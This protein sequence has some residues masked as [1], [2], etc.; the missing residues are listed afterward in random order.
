M[1]DIAWRRELRRGRAYYCSPALALGMLLVLGLVGCDFGAM[2][3]APKSHDQQPALTPGTPGV[4]VAPAGWRR[5]L[6]GQALTD[7]T[8]EN[9]MAV[10]PA[11]P[12]RL[13]AC[14]LPNT[15][16][17]AQPVFLLS[18]DEGRT[19]QSHALSGIGAHWQTCFTLADA[20]LPNTF[21]L[22]VGDPGGPNGGASQVE[23]TTDA[24]QTWRVAQTPPGDPI[25]VYA[26][27]ETTL[28]DGI[29]YANLRSSSLT[30]DEFA[31]LTPDGVWH[32]LNTTL[33]Y[34]HTPAGQTPESVTVDQSNANHVLI[35]QPTTHSVSAFL[36]AD[37]GA[38]WRAVYSW[39]SSLVVALWSG[40]SQR[41]YAQDVIHSTA[42]A[43]QFFYSEDGGVTWVG[44]G[45]HANGAYSVADSVFASPSGRVVTAWD[46]HFFT[47][48]PATGVFALLG[49]APT[50]VSEILSCVIVEGPNPSLVCT[51]G[52]DTF[53]RSLPSLT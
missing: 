5:M 22:A 36:S 42:T 37:S 18:D 44:S 28:V 48:N 6:N 38:T 29:L 51:G 7:S 47:L 30:Q 16:S 27:G 11:R 12:N 32:N 46:A 3:S 13:A 1:A 35:A 52:A 23:L 19:W 17:G 49:A 45:L 41:F 33:P 24:G 9:S 31:R 8:A 25:A 39:P 43:T 15:S 20:E 2:S 4:G 14:A 26:H 21:A 53:A 50:F 34:A 10:S 40:P